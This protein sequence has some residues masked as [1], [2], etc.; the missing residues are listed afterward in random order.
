MNYRCQLSISDAN[1]AALGTNEW[2][3]MLPEVDL[4][5]S[6]QKWATLRSCDGGRSFKVM[7][8]PRLHIVDAVEG[9]C[10]TVTHPTGELTRVD[11]ASLAV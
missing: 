11:P 8:W 7:L 9:R 1:V 5:L 4:C 2:A 3:T 6:G 10:Y